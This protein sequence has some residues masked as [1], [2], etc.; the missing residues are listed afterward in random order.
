METETPVIQEEDAFAKFGPGE[1]DAPSWAGRTARRIGDFFSHEWTLAALAALVLAAIM[2]W[3]TLRYPAYQI[4][5]DI[6]DPTL[7]AWMIS[8]GGHAMLTDPS[9]LWNANA[10]FP[11]TYSYA[12]TDT[13]LG[14]FPLGMIGSGFTAAVVRYNIIFVLLHAL[15]FFGAYMLVRQLGSGKTGAAVAG[16]AFA[17]A[18]WRLAQGGHMHVLSTGGIALSLAM[19]ARGHGFSLRHGYRP[20]KAKPGWALAGWLTAAWQISLGFGIGLPFGYVLA[21]ITVVALIGLIVRRFRSGPFVF[22]W[23][24][25]TADVVGGVAFGAV[26]ILMALP[27]LQVAEL[28]P[29][30]VRQEAEVALFSPPLFGFFVSPAESQLWGEAHKVARESLPW[31]PEMTMLPGFVLY[32]LACAGLIFSI[33]TVRQRLLLLAGVALSIF[34][35]MGSRAPGG[36]RPGYLTLY[37]ILPGWD[38][39]RTSGRLVIWTT[40]LLGILAA[41]AVSAFV[42]QAKELSLPRV[43]S[44]MPVWLRLATFIPVLLV[45]VEGQNLT[46]HPTVPRPPAALELAASPMLVLPSDQLRDEHV[47]LWLTDK[48]QPIVNGGSGFT[49]NKTQEVRELTKSFPDQASVDLLRSLGV[50]SVV[51]LREQ[52]RGT[53]YE[54]ALNA[55]GEDFGVK[56]ED[57]SDAVIFTL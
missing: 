28:H 21:V 54:G 56:R 15:A 43:T 57:R 10:F 16:A 3:P 33:W 11:N 22:S 51:V 7:E 19:L 46:P 20:E 36:G 1:E 2:T 40:L 50:K 52:V 4:P 35:A 13:L 42:E 30:A 6:W 32:G 5:Q 31:H 39:L 26:T 55:S 44:R 38:A 34:L 8:W 24:L 48:Y 14:Y 23:K 17:Y 12:F 18:P 37:D 49:P 53:P 41:G 45:L 27:Y 25:I 29:Y 9:N 47:M